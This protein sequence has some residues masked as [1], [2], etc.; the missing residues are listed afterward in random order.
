[1]STESMRRVATEILK[2][3]TAANLTIAECADI[4][5]R[6][7]I[8]LG[9]EAANGDQ[10]KAADILEPSVQQFISELRAGKVIVADKVRRGRVADS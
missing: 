4:H 9:I 7:L 10:V 5:I 8:S 6:L 3:T 1:M 2:L